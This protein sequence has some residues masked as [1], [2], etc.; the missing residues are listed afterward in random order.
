MVDNQSKEAT[1]RK[2]VKDGGWAEKNGLLV[3]SCSLDSFSDGDDD[4]GQ[5]SVNS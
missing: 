3:S 1:G 5:S 2:I 4:D